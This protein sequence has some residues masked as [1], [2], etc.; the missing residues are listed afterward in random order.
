MERVG[1]KLLI[2]SHPMEQGPEGWLFFQMRGALAEYE[3]A[4]TLE[5]THR[6]R[7]GRAKA[8]YPWGQVPFGYRAVRAPH[9]GRWEVD[10][11]EAAVVRR[12]FA[13]CLQG[14]PTREIARQL[15]L[16]RVPS[17]LDRHPKGGKSK[18][19]GQG[20]WNPGIV[21][22]MLRYEGYIGRAYWGKR[23]SITKTRRRALPPSE[24][25]ALTIP[26]I[27]DEATFQAVQQ[28]L[29]RNRVLAVRNR[30]YDYLFLG[31]RFR[32]GRCGRSMTGYPLKGVRYYR[33][34]GRNQ[35]MDPSLRCRGSIQAATIE[36]QVW[37]AVERVLRQPELIATE[38]ARQQA[39]AREGRGALIEEIRFIEAA[40][41][42]CDREEHRWAEAY[43]GEVIGLE[44]LKG[45]RAD[46]S[47]R[48]QSLQVQQ[49]ALRAQLDTIEQSVGHVDALIGYCE[50]V[51]RR[52]QTCDDAEKRLAFEA[53]DIRIT[54]T[55]N[56]PLEIQGSIPIDEIVPIP[57]G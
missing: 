56:Q 38:M 50:R 10:P 49:S 6:G 30:K 41:A 7:V 8:G 33:C 32:C 53:L 31:G 19:L 17:K 2:V 16:E 25:I 45:Y 11:E 40:L 27:I 37:V 57:S 36:S 18:G 51:H 39:N 14:L 23:Q 54:W 28:Q 34:N 47:A 15:T 48:R 46:I 9:G 29:H 55:P 44:E 3:R 22:R 20:F 24:W 26:T 12:I 1:V 21:Q 35:M 4:K 52:L 13:M 43:A 5:R 42:R